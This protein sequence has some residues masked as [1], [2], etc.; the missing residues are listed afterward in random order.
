MLV[1]MGYRCSI[2]G[3]LVLASRLLVACCTVLTGPL[4]ITFKPS[5]VRNYAKN[6][7]KSV[8]DALSGAAGIA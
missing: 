2:F 6:N 5:S 8:G 1:M 4:A 3:A 7:P